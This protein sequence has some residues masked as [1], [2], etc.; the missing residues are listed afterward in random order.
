MQT[1]SLRIGGSTLAIILAVIL[2]SPAGKAET[3]LFRG[4]PSQAVV[5]Q[6]M[7]DLQR[8]GMKAVELTYTKR[9]FSDQIADARLR[10]R[11]SCASGART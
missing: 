7:L 9:E 10:V 2:V 6:M 8:V 5:A 11:A 3:V 4:T 1:K